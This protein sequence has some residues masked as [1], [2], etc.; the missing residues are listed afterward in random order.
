ME[1]WENAF[2]IIHYLEYFTYS[3]LQKITKYAEQHFGSLTGDIPLGF[4]LGM[5]GFIGHIF[6]IPFDIRHITVSAGNTAIAYYT[7]GNSEGAAFML[8][9]LGG[10]FFYRVFQFPD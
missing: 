8:T 5:A 4:F 1:E 2:V 10:V 6:G 9:V 7:L 3:K